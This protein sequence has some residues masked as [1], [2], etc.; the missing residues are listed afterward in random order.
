MNVQ[1]RL[2][3]IPHKFRFKLLKMPNKIIM[4][5]RCFFELYEYNHKR[6]HVLI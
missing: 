3:F 6:I 4:L 2:D 1:K 5:F